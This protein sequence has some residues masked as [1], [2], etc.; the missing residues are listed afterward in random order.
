MQWIVKG[1]ADAN[2]N[3]QARPVSPMAWTSPGVRAN[4]VV[5]NGRAKDPDG[6][7]ITM[8]WWRYK[9]AGTYPGVVDLDTNRVSAARFRMPADSQPGQT[10]HLF[11]EATD[12]GIPCLP[13]MA[14]AAGLT[15]TVT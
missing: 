1:F 15:G 9:E 6:D 7:S 14:P 12:N 4:P 3:P 13:F 8:K 10:I 5:L 2:H 11:F